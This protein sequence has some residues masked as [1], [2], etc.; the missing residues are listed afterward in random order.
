MV[1][2]GLASVAVAALAVPAAVVGTAGSASAA[3][4][5]GTSGPILDPG[6]YVRQTAG[7]SANMRTGSSTACP[8]NGHYANNQDVPNYY[9]YT[10]NGTATWTYLKNEPTARTGG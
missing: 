6:A 3:A 10:F 5:C 4:A 9:C 8:N 1:S 2:Y 7:V